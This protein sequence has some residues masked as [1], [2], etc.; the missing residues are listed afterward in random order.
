MWVYWNFELI[1][2]S[3]KLPSIWIPD[4]I[5]FVSEYLQ[6]QPPKLMFLVFQKLMWI[7]NIVS[8]N[9]LLYVDKD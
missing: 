5:K 4:S 3:R 2:A 9:T 6:A 7:N 8:V 1:I